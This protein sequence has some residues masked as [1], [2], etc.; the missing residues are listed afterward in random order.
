MLNEILP[1]SEF[2]SDK[3]TSTRDGLLV[4]FFL[5]LPLVALGL[6]VFFKRNELKRRFFRKK[7]SQ[8][9][10]ADSRPQTTVSQRG[11]PSSIVKDGVVQTNKSASVPSYASRPPPPQIAR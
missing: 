8:G 2:H 6:Y 10:E 5:V 9:Y 4:F 11:N 7:R 3:D 1:L